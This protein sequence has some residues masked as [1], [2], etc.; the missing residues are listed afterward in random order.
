M[1]TSLSFQS[2]LPSN[3][4]RHILHIPLNQQPIKHVFW[5]ITQGT[6]VIKPDHPVETVQRRRSIASIH[7][8]VHPPP[9]KQSICLSRIPTSSEQDYQHQPPALGYQASGPKGRALLDLPIP[10]SKF[11]IPGSMTYE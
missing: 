1:L 11:Q 3:T 5:M 8:Q 10:T 9:P 6:L 2:D 4:T 7:L